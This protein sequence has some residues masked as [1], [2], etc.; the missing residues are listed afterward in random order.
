M[1]SLVAIAA[2]ALVGCPVV[3]VPPPPDRDGLG[4]DLGETCASLRGAGCPEGEPLPDGQTC[5]EHLTEMSVQVVVPT[6]C[7]R[8]AKAPEVVRSCGGPSELRFRCRR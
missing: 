5:F 7:L 8:A 4:T 1:R 2:L 6:A 3:R